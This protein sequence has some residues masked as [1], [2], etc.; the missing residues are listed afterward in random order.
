[1]RHSSVRIGMFSS[2]ITT[3]GDQP[4]DI[5]KQTRNL[6]VDYIS[7]PNRYVVSHCQVADGREIITSMYYSRKGYLSLIPKSV[8]Y[9]P[10][11]LRISTSST[12]TASNSPARSIP[13][14]RITYLKLPS[15]TSRVISTHSLSFKAVARSVSLPNSIS[16]T[17]ALTLSTSSRVAP[18][19]SNL[20]S[21]ASSTARSR[22]F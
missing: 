15:C 14:V 12:R 19:P 18:T 17:P 6:I 13:K 1:M 5:E 3:T 21:L 10:L 16:W 20:A 2:T 9:W 7:K 22:T 11:P 8:S 4:T